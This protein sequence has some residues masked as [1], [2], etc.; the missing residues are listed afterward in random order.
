MKKIAIGIIL[1][2]LVVLGVFLMNTNKEEDAQAEQYETWVRERRPLMVERE[3]CEK[4]I[5]ELQKEYDKN[6]IPRATTHVIFTDLDERV[7]KECRSV[8][9]EFEYTGTLVVSPAQL[10]GQENCMSV[11][12]FQKL[13]EAG[14]KVCVQ[15]DESFSNERLWNAFKLELDMLDIRMGKQIYFPAGT[16]SSELDEQIADKGFSIIIREFKDGD[17]VTDFEYNEE[18][19]HVNAINFMSAQ[20]KKWLKEVVAKQ[21]NIVYTVTFLEEEV[22][23]NADSFQRMLE[24]F[25]EY[26]SNEELLVKDVLDAHEYYGDMLRDKDS[27]YKAKYEKEKKK[28]EKRIKEIDDMLKEIDEKYQ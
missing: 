14:W 25:D 13:T 10:P 17:E 7:Y 16:Y 9:K 27:E 20:P 12:Q 23:Y 26:V 28:I 22:M 1:V 3:E 21:R 18:T 15:W 5:D 4:K 6:T 2:M 8:M 19:W 24:T 11:K